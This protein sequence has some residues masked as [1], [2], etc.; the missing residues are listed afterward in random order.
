MTQCVNFLF[1]FTWTQ[2]YLANVVFVD[3]DHV[4][5]LDLVVGATAPIVVAVAMRGKTQHSKLFKKGLKYKHNS[6]ISCL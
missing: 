6:L 3:L 5:G 1:Y 2:T 4:L